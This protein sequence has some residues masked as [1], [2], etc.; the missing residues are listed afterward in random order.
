M[1]L[2]GPVV[3]TAFPWA[4]LTANGGGARG[5]KAWLLW[6]PPLVDAR[7]LGIVQ[8]ARRRQDRFRRRDDLVQLR[9]LDLS[10]NEVQMLEAKVFHYMTSLVKLNLRN[11][12]LSQISPDVFLQA[13]T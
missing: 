6:A 12:R 9:V 11:N 2:V 3:A 1:Q 7:I 13:R 5:L 8:C 10:H 4:T